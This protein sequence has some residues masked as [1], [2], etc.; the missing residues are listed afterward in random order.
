MLE[1]AR[2]DYGVDMNCDQPHFGCHSNGKLKPMAH[3]FYKTQS[4][5]KFSIDN[6][7]DFIHKVRNLYMKKKNH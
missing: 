7:Y 4:T 6:E 2:R 1:W 5:A 3:T